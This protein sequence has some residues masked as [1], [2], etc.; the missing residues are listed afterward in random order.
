[1]VLSQQAFCNVFDLTFFEF[2]V[3]LNFAYYFSF[4]KMLTISNRLIKNTFV[5]KHIQ[6]NEA[7]SKTKKD[8][9]TLSSQTI[10]HKKTE[11]IILNKIRFLRYGK[12]LKEAP[13]KMGKNRFETEQNIKFLIGMFC[14]ENGNAPVP[15]FVQTH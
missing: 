12:K 8:K 7:K 14:R 1:M 4:S 9:L 6:R 2:S 10:F 3:V 11:S 5:E 13:F 15:I